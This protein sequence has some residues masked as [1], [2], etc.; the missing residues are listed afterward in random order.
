MGTRCSST[1]CGNAHKCPFPYTHFRSH[2]SPPQTQPSRVWTSNGL[3]NRR[4]AGKWNQLDSLAPQPVAFATATQ[5]TYGQLHPTAYPTGRRCHGWWEAIKP[6]AVPLAHTPW[7]VFQGKPKLPK[8]YT[9]R[10][11]ISGAGRQILK[12]SFRSP[13]DS[14]APLPLSN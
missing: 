5:G 11:S 9:N 2:R 8:Q 10:L 12:P 14:P 6:I 4:A 1:V 13:G 7:T 3:D